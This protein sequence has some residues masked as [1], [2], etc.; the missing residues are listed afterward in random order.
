MAPPLP[1][2]VRGR[3]G[4][5]ALMFLLLALGGCV[6]SRSPEQFHAHGHVAG[7]LINTRVDSPLAEYY[8]EDF[9][10]GHP[11]RADLNEELRHIES[12]L[13]PGI[14]DRDTLKWITRHHSRDVA[15]IFLVERLA[16]DPL[17]RQF[18][19]LYLQ[20]LELVISGG[21]NESMPTPLKSD[22]V[23]LVVP[24]WYWRSPSFDGSLEVP[25]QHLE[26]YGYETALVSTDEQGSVEENAEVVADRLRQLKKSGTSVV[27][28]SV[29]K[30]G[31]EAALALG[32]LL[33]W[34]ESEHVVAW[35]NVNG[36]LRGSPLAD[37]ML[38]WRRTVFTHM[39]MWLV[40]RDSVKS[41]RSMRTGHRR[42]VFSSLQFPPHLLVVN[43]TAVP[44]SGQVTPRRFRYERLLNDDG[45][46]DGS[47]LTRDEL[48]AGVPTVVE[49]GFDHYFFD[50]MIGHKAHALVRALET[51]LPVAG[52]P[53][54]PPRTP[55][56]RG[57]APV[58]L[59][60]VEPSVSSRQQPAP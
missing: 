25:R 7:S 51:W 50:P 10:R 12:R 57:T 54:A 21:A 55:A 33:T 35:I 44:F 9:S 15:T 59:G 58:P 19:D 48:I 46:N 53:L 6:G 1:H 38:S 23:F 27:L 39:L 28:V 29:S 4:E 49:I 26:R 45:P 40:H 30:G 41:L 13:E 36:G 32:G 37:E 17:N 31:A 5:L 8:L 22:V 3:P 43:F 52:M 56:S 42:R 2:G 14:P 24:G 16:S 11:H 47:L 20:Q 34:E 18:S 60:T